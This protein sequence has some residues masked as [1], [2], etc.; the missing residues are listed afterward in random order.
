M[1]A[2]VNKVLEPDERI[3]YTAKLSRIAYVPAWLVILI[4][5]VLAIFTY[6]IPY[7]IYVAW[8]IIAVGVVWMVMTWITRTTTEIAVTDRRVILKTGLISRRTVEM[9]L[10][11][12]ES[13]DVRQGILGRLL[14]FGDVLIRGTGA[15]LEPIKAVD[16]P[17]EFRRRVLS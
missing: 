9:N 1:V 15:G 2:Y 11:R 3:S 14:N 7:V 4:G 12:I 6:Q 8:A 13:V 16:A 10:T 5:I 17:L